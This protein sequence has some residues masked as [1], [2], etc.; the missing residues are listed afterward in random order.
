MKGTKVDRTLNINMIAL[1]RGI[2]TF[3][4]LLRIETL[5]RKIK[6]LKRALKNNTLN[7]LK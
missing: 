4:R 3:V 1:K 2:K 5:N 7:G 6:R